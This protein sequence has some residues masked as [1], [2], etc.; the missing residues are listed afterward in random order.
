VGREETSD[1]GE[2][3]RLLLGSIRLARR[4]ADCGLV[5]LVPVEL[6]VLPQ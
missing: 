2:N 6:G 1:T 3:Q 4:L 5:G